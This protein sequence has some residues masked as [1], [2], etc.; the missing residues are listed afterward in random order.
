MEMVI[1]KMKFNIF[2]IEYHWYEGEYDETFLGKNVERKEFEKDL[3]EAKNFAKSLVGKKIETGDYLSK[4]YSVECLPEYYQQIIWFL[5]DKK[6]YV[7][8]SFNEDITYN[9]NDDFEGNIK[10]SKYEKS[11]IEPELK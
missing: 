1:R 6:G 9:L 2:K 7:E 8:C 3:I 4:G 5:V 11:I 10:L